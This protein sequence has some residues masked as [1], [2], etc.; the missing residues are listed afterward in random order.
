MLSIRYEELLRQDPVLVLYTPLD[1]EVYVGP[2]VSS[3]T[4]VFNKD[5]SGEYTNILY[6]ATTT[7]PE[8]MQPPVPPAPSQTGGGIRI[9]DVTNVPF[10]YE[11]TPSGE[12]T[13]YDG[14]FVYMGSISLNW[15]H[16]T[17]LNVN[18]P[19]LIRSLPK[20]FGY[21]ICTEARTLIRVLE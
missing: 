15:S 12:I 21:T 19:P 14:D 2:T 20:P 8:G 4:W 18:D 10:T 6:A 5:M 16:M 9:F 7:P 17:L 13:V 1:S 3:G 11:I